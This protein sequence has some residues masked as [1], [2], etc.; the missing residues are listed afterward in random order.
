MFKVQ[1]ATLQA[2]ATQTRILRTP[3]KVERH[4]EEALTNAEKCIIA[5][6]FHINGYLQ[7]FLS[8]FYFFIFYFT[9]LK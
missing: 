1:A 9:Y 8:C 3:V 5:Q 6:V 7:L 4:S 2:S